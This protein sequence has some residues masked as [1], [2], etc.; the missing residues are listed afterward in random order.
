M[1]LTIEL[2]MDNA[3]FVDGGTEEVRRVLDGL[4]DRLPEPLDD[5]NGDI[6]LHD[7][8]GNWIGKARIQ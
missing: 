5:T 4:C 8:N 2:T 3:A 7:L 1:K 6:T